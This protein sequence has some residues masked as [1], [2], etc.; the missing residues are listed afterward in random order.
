MLTFVICFL[1]PKSIFDE[2]EAEKSLIYFQNIKRLTKSHHQQI[3]EDLKKLHS[4]DDDNNKI[5]LADFSE[6]NIDNNEIFI[7]IMIQFLEES[8]R[9]RKALIYG[10]CLMALNQ[11]AGVFAMLNFTASIF[12][13]SGSSFKPNVATILVGAIQIIGSIFPMLLVDRLGRKVMMIVSAIGSSLGLFAHGVF[14]LLKAKEYEIETFNWIP[15]AALSFTIF[16][17]N[18]STISKLRN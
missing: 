18:V 7:V 4:T 17:A 3:V 14:A 1:S 10:I 16:I 15:V 2:K 13:E 9:V 6:F 8:A 5:S 12:E 11:F